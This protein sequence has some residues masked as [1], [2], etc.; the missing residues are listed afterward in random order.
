MRVLPPAG[1]A[2][3]ISISTAEESAHWKERISVDRLTDEK[4][5]MMTTPALRPIRQFGRNVSATLFLH[6]REELDHKKYRDVT[7]LFSERVAVDNIGARYR[8]DSDPVEV[9]IAN[10]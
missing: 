6:C 4:V 8:I 1:L 9:K 10:L 2:T 7:V 3:L 5:V